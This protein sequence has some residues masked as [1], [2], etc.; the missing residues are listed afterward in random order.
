MA[1]VGNAVGLS[2]GQPLDSLWA[3]SASEEAVARSAIPGV[4]VIGG[5][6]LIWSGYFF[7]EWVPLSCTCVGVHYLEESIRTL[8]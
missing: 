1:G 8:N 4:V 7:R 5:L 6:K 3:E 2:N